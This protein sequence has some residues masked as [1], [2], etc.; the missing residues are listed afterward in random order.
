MQ[1]GYRLLAF[2]FVLLQPEALYAQSL[3]FSRN[4][5]TFETVN[6]SLV[7]KSL[8]HAC[9]SLIQNPDGLPC[10]PAN[11]PMSKKPRLGI[12]I[13]LSNGYSALNNVR[14]LI[15]GDIDQELVDKLFEERK[16]L[17]IEAS[18]QIN[19]Q[20]AYFNARY[21][22][23]SVTGF[24][25]VRNE[26]NPE[27]EISVIEESG[28][29]F[30]SGY[31]LLGGFYVG[32]QLRFVERKF[33]EKQFRLVELGTPAGKDLLK[34]QKQSATYIEPGITWIIAES[35]KPR[36]S[37]FMANLGFESERYEELGIQPDPQVGLGLSPPVR[38][39]SLELTLDYKSLTYNEPDIEKFRLGGL[40][41]FGAMN[42][43]GGID[44]NGVSGG[45]YYSIEQVN[46]GVM[47]STTRLTN[48]D[49]EYF[50]QT[51]YVQLGWK[52]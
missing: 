52:I 28:F 46:A 18:S 38:W 26:A 19:F 6:A 5:R 34:P 51:V 17:Q 9:L 1:W 40:Y 36:I 24:S 4:A 39:G 41:Q 35:W 20:S 31:E 29:L 48:Q 15:K 47:Y 12:D 10:N 23:L 49:E 43:S 32:A 50:T 27:V 44:A 37:L 42:L 45:I 3:A 11:V 30:Q 13:L 33:I 25:V 14:E 7:Q 2:W 22:P 21:S 16:I 8:A